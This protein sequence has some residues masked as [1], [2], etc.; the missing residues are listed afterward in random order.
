MKINYLTIIY[1]SEEEKKEYNIYKIT[2]NENGK[3]YIGQTCG[4]IISRFCQHIWY[5]LNKKHDY[6]KN[7]DIYPTN[8]FMMEIR[9]II[10]TWKN[11]FQV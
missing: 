8:K 5:A 1:M 2:N 9:E 6:S 10:N 11:I 4:H 3:V 7:M